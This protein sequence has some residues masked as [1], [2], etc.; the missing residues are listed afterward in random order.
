M[1]FNFF[2]TDNFYKGVGNFYGGGYSV[3]YT[4]QIYLVD[5]FFNIKNFVTFFT[6][7]NNFSINVLNNFY[8]TESYQSTMLNTHTLSYIELL[9]SAH[10][11]KTNSLVFFS[12]L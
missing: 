4:N 1:Q 9:F 2:F 12:N 7:N 5:F 6:Y 8:S 3:F 10:F 11:D